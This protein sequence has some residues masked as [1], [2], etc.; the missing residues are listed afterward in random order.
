MDFATLG[1]VI[2]NSDVQDTDEA[3]DQMG[4]AGEAAAK[5]IQQAWKQV[6][7]FSATGATFTGGVYQ[8]TQSLGQLQNAQDQL[9][10]SLEHGGRAVTEL[11]RGLVALALQG[12]STVGPVSEITQA[13]LLMG[14]GIEVL[15]GVAAAVATVGLAYK[16]LTADTTAD[17]QAQDELAKS[18]DGMGTHAKLAADQLRLAQL[19]AQQ[20]DSSVGTVLLRGLKAFAGPLLGGASFDEQQQD[21]ERR[22]ATLRTEIARLSGELESPFNKALADASEG[23]KEAQIR[24]ALMGETTDVVNE[25][26][27]RQKATY[28]KLTP[29]EAAQLA[30]KQR[31]AEVLNATTAAYRSALVALDDAV[32][33]QTMLWA[34]TE[35]LNAAL[36]KN[37]EL[38]AHIDPGKAAADAAMSQAAAELK[39]IQ[40]LVKTARDQ[41]QTGFSNFFQGIEDDG[42]AHFRNLFDAIRAAYEQ[43]I[44]DLAAKKVMQQVTSTVGPG[45]M[46]AIG[47]G[48][49]GFGAGESSGVLGGVISGAAAGA[50]IPGGG[51]VTAILGAVSGLVGGLFGDAEKAREAADALHKVQVQFGTDLQAFVDAT[52]QTASQ[53]RDQAEQLRQEAIAARGVSATASGPAEAAQLD[54]EL[55]H[56]YAVRAANRTNHQVVE[57]LNQQIYALQREI[58]ALNT[59]NAAEQ[60]RLDELKAESLDSYQIRLLTAK[61]Q[62]VTADALALE[63]QQRQ[64]YN[65]AVQDGADATQLAALQEV[66]LAETRRAAIDRLQ[67][68]IDGLTTTINDLAK[69]Q[70][71]LRLG[72][73]TALSP[74]Q[75][76]QAARQQYQQVVGQAEAGNQTAAQQLPDVAQA[77]LQASR[78]VNASGGRYQA[79]FTT[80]LSDAAQVQQLFEGQRTAAQAQ[81]DLLQS[82][83]DAMQNI[84]SDLGII[85]SGHLIPDR[86]PPD[87]LQK[88]DVL[89]AA[90]ADTNARL[91]GVIGVLQ[92]GFKASIDATTQAIQAEGSSTR[93]ALEGMAL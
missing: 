85:V 59:I 41:M 10:P 48:V 9:N 28:D 4:A 51:P 8:A 23:L 43:L 6:Q 92:A 93:L 3:L 89:A 91:D 18:L 62:T 54:A 26:I 63:L 24:A 67:T 13:V 15:L 25:A 32:T 45:G 81:V 71:D 39:A 84:A 55:Q 74:I 12:A 77:F 29:A 68:Q 42:I 73:L 61:G 34:S 27:N 64:E 37:A 53:I 50:L 47:A 79:D 16:A 33:G 7:V 60:K 38:R 83:L 76:L 58:D 21:L 65:Q 69:F 88:L 2:D 46:A 5:R 56:L 75:Q 11:K 90:S 14:G 80:V 31:E 30:A 19:Q 35:Q 20:Q 44:G 72:S 52:G 86:S 40:A 49:V 36:Q 57:M 17:R 22:M 78:A 1:I 87:I 70:T 66:Q 82:Q